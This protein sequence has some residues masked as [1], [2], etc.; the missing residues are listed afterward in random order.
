MRCKVLT[1]GLLYVHCF[2][3]FV[4]K[5]HANSL[6]CLHHPALKDHYVLFQYIKFISH[7]NFQRITSLMRTP[8]TK[9]LGELVTKVYKSSFFFFFLG[10]GGGGGGGVSRPSSITAPTYATYSPLWKRVIAWV[11]SS[12]PS[13]CGKVWGDVGYCHRIQRPPKQSHNPLVSYSR[14]RPSLFSKVGYLQQVG[15][16]HSSTF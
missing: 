12:C 13:D 11:E 10:G 2:L 5:V 3:Q 14:P 4:F 16:K 7:T 6:H 9:Y 15:V 8:S 1:F